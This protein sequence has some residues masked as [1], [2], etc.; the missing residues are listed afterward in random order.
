MRWLRCVP[1]PHLY[2]GSPT[3]VLLYARACAGK[4]SEPVNRQTRR[5][6]NYGPAGSLDREARS[7]E[8]RCRLTA[9]LRALY[10]A[11]ALT[12]SSPVMGCIWRVSVARFCQGICRPKART[13]LAL[14]NE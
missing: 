3:L 13:S 11:K 7:K 8:L 4:L 6:D 12:A 1:C 14:A 2:I 10:E 9:E 5:R